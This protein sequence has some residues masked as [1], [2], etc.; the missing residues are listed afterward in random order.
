MRIAMLIPA[1]WPET[2]RGSERVVHD[3]ATLLADRGHDVTV[4]TT[5]AGRTESSV[6]DGVA[7]V[8]MRRPPRVPQLRWYEDHLDWAV[9]IVYRLVRGDYDVAHAFHPSCAY[10]ALEAQRW[11]A[12]PLVFSIHGIPIRRFLV[13]KRYRIEMLRKTVEGAAVNTVLSEAAADAFRR[14]LLR[15]P[16][17]LPAGFHHSA[18]SSDAEREPVPT[19]LCAASLDDARKRGEVLVNAFR[20]LKEIRADAR[21]LL[22]PPPGAPRPEF[23]LPEGAE[24]VEAHT[25]EQ[26]ARLYASAWVTVLAAVEEAQGLVLVESLASG[27]P[28]VAARSG[29]GPEIVESDAVGRLFE[30]DDEADLARAM[31]EALDLVSQPAVAERCRASAGRFSWEPLVDQCEQIYSEA[32]GPAQR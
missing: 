5:H 23:D 16:R 8:R 28:V 14:Y 27:T 13:E 2:K 12:P 24:W 6:E 17:V 3:S 21:L 7:V 15:E 19:L 26:L 4:L 1:Y 29:A 10:L 32:I 11:G 25:T 18:F 20:T 31:D 22:A 30:P 9:P